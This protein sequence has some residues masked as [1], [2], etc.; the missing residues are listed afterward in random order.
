MLE[1]QN[2]I[3]LT[4]FLKSITTYP[5][6]FSDERV[7]RYDTLVK[8]STSV[9][10]DRDINILIL[11]KVNKDISTLKV[12]DDLTIIG[13]LDFMD[14][15]KKK[16]WFEAADEA[17]VFRNRCFNSNELIVLGSYELF[18]H[19]TKNVENGSLAVLINNSIEENMKAISY[20]VFL[21][22]HN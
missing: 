17:N 14:F 19:T 5:Y 8:L 11:D 22:K 21:S 16:S 6:R 12:G 4:G 20:D 13:K 10:R 15:T 18:I 7:V 1:I 3:C 2:T 9:H